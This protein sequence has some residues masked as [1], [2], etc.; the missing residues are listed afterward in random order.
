[1]N[2]KKLGAL[3]ATAICLSSTAF[4]GSK[5]EIL[6]EIAS[7]NKDLKEKCGCTVQ[8]SF[9]P[10]IDFTNDYGRS[11]AFNIEKM[12]ESVGEGAGRWCQQSPDHAAKFCAMVKS[13][14]A[15]EDKTVE[16]P[17]TTNKGPAVVSYIATKIPAQIMNHG[18]AWLEDFLQTGKMPARK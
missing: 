10:K 18:D 14:H 12:F 17:Y 16:D 3:V 2:T 1:M 8:F 11:L 13:V 7:T 9:S 4:A 6:E 5:K 15:E